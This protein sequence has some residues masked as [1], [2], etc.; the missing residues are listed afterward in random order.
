ML[1]CLETPA[2]PLEVPSHLA[3]PLETPAPP[4]EVPSHLAPPLE[5]PW[6]RA[7]KPQVRR[8]SEPLGTN[9][10][11]KIV[12]FRWFLGPSDQNELYHTP[13][14][15]KILQKILHVEVLSEIG[16]KLL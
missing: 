7:S 2:P 16:L 9:F 10:E 15:S 1:L 13:L 3:L 6:R 8:A 11:T 12:K 14:L 5:T 4:L